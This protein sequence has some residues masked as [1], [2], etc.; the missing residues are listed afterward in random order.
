M[1]KVKLIKYLAVVSLCSCLFVHQASADVELSGS[2]ILGSLDILTFDETNTGKVEGQFNN[3]LALTD[4]TDAYDTTHGRS[5]STFS[6]DFAGAR[7][8]QPQMTVNR[9]ELTSV[10]F[11]D[12]GWFDV[13]SL[14]PI[15]QVTRDQSILSFGQGN[16]NNTDEI[17]ETI[18]STS[19]YPVDSSDGAPGS[20][21]TGGVY[22]FDFAP[23]DNVYAV[24]ILG[25]PGG[26][27]L[28]DSDGDFIGVREVRVFSVE[29]QPPIQNPNIALSGTAIF[30]LNAVDNGSYGVDYEHAGSVTTLNDGFLFGGSDTWNG[31]GTEPFEFAGVM[32]DEP[33]S[34]VDR[35]VLYHRTFGDGGWFADTIE[36]TDFG[37]MEPKVQFT[38]DG[39]LTWQDISGVVSDYIDVMTG[40][41]P[42][43]AGTTSNPITFEFDSLGAIDGIRVFGN[44][45]GTASGGFIGVAELEVYQTVI[46]TPAALP[47]GMMLLGMP[48]LRRRRKARS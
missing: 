18:P 34:D 31:A 29:E 22:T 3:M 28:G 25:D 7:F 24:R 47:L 32:F 9:I 48:L 44:G 27:A 35:F 40:S 15:V 2:G 16:F 42:T 38:T 19:N 13:S 21:V 1:L 8:I 30:G 5:T 43:A 6:A 4:G 26:G 33:T 10:I 17:W 36:N 11:G 41:V 23:Q 46:P 14:A 12:G 39:G 37:L 45:G 20:V